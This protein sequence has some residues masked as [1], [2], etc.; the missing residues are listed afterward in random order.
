MNVIKTSI[1]IFEQH[2]ILCLLNTGCAIHHFRSVL[3]S[4]FVPCYLARL[5]S[6]IQYSCSVGIIKW[7][8]LTATSYLVL[9]CTFGYL[10]YRVPLIHCYWSM[11]ANIYMMC[12]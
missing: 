4:T 2:I 6:A 5:F 12:I 10:L 1:K 8:S 3:I 11:K 7:V 9:C